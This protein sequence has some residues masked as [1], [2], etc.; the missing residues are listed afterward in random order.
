MVT[1]GDDSVYGFAAQRLLAARRRLVVMDRRGYGRSPD[2]ECSD[3]ASDAN[4]LVGLL[5]HRAEGAHPQRPYSSRAHSPGMLLMG[6]KLPG[7]RHR[8]HCSGTALATGGLLA[9]DRPVAF[10]HLLLG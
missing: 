10:I 1:S 8:H 5:A 3:Y 6:E 9:P 7:I 2:I 4:D